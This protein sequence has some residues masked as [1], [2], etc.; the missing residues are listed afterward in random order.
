M[1]RYEQYIENVNLEDYSYDAP[2]AVK[3]H[4]HGSDSD[5]RSPERKMEGKA[6]SRP[7]VLSNNKK[8]PTDFN[9]KRTQKPQSMQLIREQ[10]ENQES[11]VKKKIREE[12][13]SI[14][15]RS[16]SKDS[17]KIHFPCSD[18]KLPQVFRLRSISH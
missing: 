10:A 9:L 11:P 4:E 2:N 15:K 16:L 18:K 14:S 13:E 5:E 3:T 8:F 17:P 12:I 1:R 6:R 7:K